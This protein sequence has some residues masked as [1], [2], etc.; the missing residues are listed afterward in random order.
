MKTYAL[1]AA[2]ATFT[3]LAA[4]PAQAGTKD[5]IAICSNPHLTTLERK[6]C[7]AEMRAA[8]TDAE[9]TQVF[10]TYDLRIIGY[11]VNGARLA[12]TVQEAE[13]VTQ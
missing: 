10:R 9:R 4:I 8:T 7:R 13:A 11:D 5:Y 6:T 1:A 3:A 2:L 12:D